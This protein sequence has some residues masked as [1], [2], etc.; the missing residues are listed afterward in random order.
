MKVGAYLAKEKGWRWVFWLVSII[1]RLPLHSSHELAN[2]HNQGG[3][4]F[5]FTLAFLRE[6]YAPTIL[7]RK[8][9]RKQKETGNPSLKSA[10]ATDTKPLPL[11]KESIFRPVQM[12]IFSPMVLLISLY[13]GT[14]YSY[15]Y[16]LFTTFPR[17]YIGQY[18]FSTETVGLVYLGTGIGSFIG[19]FV[20]GIVSDR[21]VTALAKKHGRGPIPEYRLPITVVGACIIPAGIFMYGWCAEKKVHWIAPIMGTFVLGFGMFIVFVGHGL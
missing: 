8:T 17:V 12:L 10:L 3:F 16:L 15:L 4:V 7:N 6:S 18:L 5:L 11:F 20:C 13:L 14:I 2:N 19:L 21:I 9:K 1:V